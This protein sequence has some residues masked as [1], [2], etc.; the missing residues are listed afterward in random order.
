MS[1]TKI[2]TESMGGEVADFI[3]KWIG[4]TIQCFGIC[5]GKRQ[6]NQFKGYPHDDGLAD[7]SGNKYWV[8]FE[9]PKCKYGHSFIK[10]N[11]FLDHTRIEE[12]A[13]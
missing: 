5:R 4:K 10:M 6:V 2:M 12:E 9:C 1:D 8:Y 11:F 3:N 13:E 7:S